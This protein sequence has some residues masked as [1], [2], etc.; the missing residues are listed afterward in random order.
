MAPRLLFFGILKHK[1][2]DRSFQ[3]IEEIPDA[4]TTI[5]EDLTF[6]DLQSILFNRMEHLD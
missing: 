3:I 6:E 4:V 5:L 2:K 1:M